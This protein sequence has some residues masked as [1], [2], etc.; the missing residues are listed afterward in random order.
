MASRIRDALG[1]KVS[2]GSNVS[3]VTITGGKGT[4]TRRG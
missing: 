4:P 1:A 3:G 2:C